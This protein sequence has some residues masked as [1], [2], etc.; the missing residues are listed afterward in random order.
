MKSAAVK[1]TNNKT[2][3]QLTQLTSAERRDKKSLLKEK[4]YFHLN[5][6]WQ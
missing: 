1:E 5:K 6:K 3:L 4:A 2:T